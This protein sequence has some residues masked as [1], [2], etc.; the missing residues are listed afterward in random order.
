MP[1]GTVPFSERFAIAFSGI[2][3]IKIT[4]VDK[5]GTLKLRFFII[6]W[7]VKVLIFT[8]FGRSKSRFLIALGAR[9]P[10]LDDLGPF[11]MPEVPF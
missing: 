3:E 11:W 5:G 8:N 4:I 6:F 9:E 2:W 7:N 1:S 10:T